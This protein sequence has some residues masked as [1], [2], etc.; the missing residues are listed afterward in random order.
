MNAAEQSTKVRTF[1]A[2]LLAQKG[3]RKAFSDSD[4]LGQAGRL[5]SLDLLEVVQFLEQDFGVD[6]SAT[7]F[8]PTRLGSVDQIVT[9]IDPRGWP[10]ELPTEDRD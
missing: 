1:L 4:A 10:T 7:E 8:D 5:D 6:F 9:L 2:G 3:D